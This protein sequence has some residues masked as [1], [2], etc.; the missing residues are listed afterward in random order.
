MDTAAR[1]KR[2][3]TLLHVAKTRLMLADDEYRSLLAT[4]SGGK[5]SSTKLSLPELEE[6]LRHMKARGFVVAQRQT[7]SSDLKIVPAHADVDAQI[8]KIRALWLEL[9]DLGAVRNSSELALARFVK[10]H[11]G[12]DYHGWLGTDD[13]SAIIEHLKQWKRRVK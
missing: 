13:A 4:V 6:A 2:L 7:V 1:K 9:H 3:V 12:V 10:R 11:T 5:T 8:R